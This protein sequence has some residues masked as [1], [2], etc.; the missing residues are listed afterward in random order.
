VDETI[1]RTSRTSND[2]GDVYVG[3]NNYISSSQV[4]PIG[5]SGSTNQAYEQELLRLRSKYPN[6]IDDVYANDRYLNELAILQRKYSHTDIEKVY[7]NDLAFKPNKEVNPLGNSGSI[8]DT[9]NNPTDIN[10]YNPQNLGKVYP[11]D[12]SFKPNKEINPLG[13]TGSIND[14][15]EQELAKLRSKYPNKLSD[16]YTNDKYNQEL[17]RLTDRY[18]KSGI[19]KIYPDDLAFKSN[20]GVKEIKKIYPDDLNFKPT[21]EKQTKEINQLGDVYP[22]V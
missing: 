17:A 16:V 13:N 20:L 6:H 1:N 3:D 2:L 9:T 12:L 18:K 10:K 21:K 11:D 14:A 22:E 7:S 5:N 4:K 8:N 15:Y 19:Q